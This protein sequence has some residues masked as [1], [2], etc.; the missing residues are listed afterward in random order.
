MNEAALAAGVKAI[1]VA[2]ANTPLETLA[3]GAGIKDEGQVSRVRSGQLGAKLTEV[4]G[5]IYAAGFKCVSI[6][7]ICVDR[8]MYE[9]MVTVNARVMRDEQTVRRLTWDE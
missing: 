8:A 2:M 4:L 5:M 6:E 7:K 3:K 9:A 1:E